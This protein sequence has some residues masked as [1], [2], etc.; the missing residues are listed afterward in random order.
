MYDRWVGSSCGCSWMGT[1]HEIGC[2]NSGGIRNRQA[3]V[4]E[5]A[6]DGR[7]T[8]KGL[9]ILFIDRRHRGLL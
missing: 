7:N 3:W 5:G 1:H 8:R 6:D 4:N 9:F 2:V